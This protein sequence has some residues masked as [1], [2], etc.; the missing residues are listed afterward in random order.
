[1]LKDSDTTHSF[2]IDC[3][4]P[5]AMSVALQ[6]PPAPPV[7]SGLLPAINLH[8]VTDHWVSSYLNPNMKKVFVY[9]SLNKPYRLGRVRPQLKVLYGDLS[10]DVGYPMVTQQASDPLCGALAV[11]FAIS[12]LMGIPPQTQNFDI[13]QVR[14][15]LQWCIRHHSISQFPVMQN[16]VTLQCQSIPNKSMG[17]TQTIT[18]TTSTKQTITKVSSPTACRVASTTATNVAIRHSSSATVGALTA[19]NVDPRQSSSALATTNSAPR[20]YTP[21][22]SYLQQQ[23]DAQFL[24]KQQRQQRWLSKPGMYYYSKNTMAVQYVVISVA[25]TSVLPQ[26]Q[27]N[28]VGSDLYS[29]PVKTHQ[30]ELLHVC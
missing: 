11:A 26:L 10:N 1:M 24:L 9:D 6:E 5:A 21:I 27:R 8:H 2:E 15:H 18:I 12:C 19:T 29:F 20:F 23:H 4:T 28:F 14:A 30:T 13:S 7:C 25:A 22:A 17:L 16:P 3:L